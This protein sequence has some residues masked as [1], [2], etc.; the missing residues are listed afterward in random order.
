LSTLDIVIILLVLFGAYRGYRDGFLMG[1]ATLL[2]LVLGILGAFKLTGEGMEFL[3]EHFNA[4]KDFLPY[5]SFFMIFLAIVALVTIMGR[6][7]RHSIDKTFLGRIDESA[8]SL[9]GALKTLFM[10]SVVLWI[11][12]SLKVDLPD[13]WTKGSLVYPFTAQLAPSLASWVGQF[14]PFLEDVFPVF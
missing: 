3:Q 11:V 6:F 12:D 14:L 2:A 4:D 5:I 13:D 10:L 1:V 8:G 9:L 7:L